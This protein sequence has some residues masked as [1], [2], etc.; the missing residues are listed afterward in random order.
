MSMIEVMMAM[1]MAMVIALG[2]FSMLQYTAKISK[3]ASVAADWMSF[4]NTIYL[5]L[6]NATICDQ[7]I[8]K[9]GAENRLTLNAKDNYDY[10]HAIELPAM[11]YAVGP[12]TQTLVA[13]NQDRNG[14]VVRHVKMWA[15]SNPE[16]L[17][18]DPTNNLTYNKYLV[19]TQFEA[20]R[21]QS[22][23]GGG[24]AMA[25][26][27]FTVDFKILTGPDTT[28]VP[29]IQDELKGCVPNSL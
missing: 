28:V 1:S 26:A 27:P 15:I 3:S 5:T 9:I 7:I 18:L 10:A 11:T 29:N 19:R 17:P 6:T 13:P 8:G 23:Q 24:S 2:V 21:S 4:K 14:Y 16:P 25:L 22:L 20:E 12:A